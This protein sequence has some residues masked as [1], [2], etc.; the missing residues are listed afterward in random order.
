MN[1]Q[2]QNSDVSFPYPRSPP[3]RVATPPPNAAEFADAF[4]YFHQSR[5]VFSP[6]ATGLTPLNASLSQQESTCSNNHQSN[7][8]QL[9]RTSR[10]FEVRESSKQGEVGDC[11]TRGEI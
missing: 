7:L 1:S 10:N 8:G 5:E 2:S 4:P 11:S 6:T 3:P 9:S